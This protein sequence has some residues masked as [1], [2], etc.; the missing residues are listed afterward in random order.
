MNGRFGFSPAAHEARAGFFFFRP[1][2]EWQ[3]KKSI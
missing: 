2:K 3:E 1:V